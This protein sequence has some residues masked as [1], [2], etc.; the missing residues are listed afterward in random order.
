M[1]KLTRLKVDGEFPICL[2]IDESKLPISIK[3]LIDVIGENKPVS[4]SGQRTPIYTLSN[5][6]YL[7]AKGFDYQRRNYQEMQE[8]VLDT[9]QPLT[10]ERAKQLGLQMQFFERPIPTRFKEESGHHYQ[11]IP[12]EDGTFKKRLSQSRP[13]GAMTLDKV[14]VE[15]ASHLWARN[16]NL[17]VDMPLGFAEFPE[18]GF[19]EKGKSIPCGGFLAIIPTHYDLRV[20]EIVYHLPHSEELQNLYQHNDNLVLLVQSLYLAGNIL[21]NFHKNN[22]TLTNCHGMNLKVG[23]VQDDFTARMQSDSGLPEISICDLDGTEYCQNQNVL[24]ASI[25]N[26]LEEMLLVPNAFLTTVKPESYIR[27]KKDD[28]QRYMFDLTFRIVSELDLNEDKNYPKKAFYAGYL[29]LQPDHKLLPYLP[30]QPF[31]DILRI[32]KPI[33]EI[34]NPLL[35]LLRKLYSSI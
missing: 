25:I 31:Q 14:L 19:K 29:N 20:P 26:D 23:L 21:R 4:F 32:K 22:R 6:L 2:Y 35:D 13:I 24:L 10:I 17:P 3:E 34:Q 11:Q 9:N 1:P 16:Q 5:G 28:D 18:F 7:R 30:E 8:H 33:T 27:S 15:Y 12:Q